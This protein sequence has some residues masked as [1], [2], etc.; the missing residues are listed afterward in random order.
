MKKSKKILIAILIIIALIGIVFLTY[1]VLDEKQQA[2][3]NEEYKLNGYIIK[4][5]ETEEE[6]F[7]EDVLNENEI[8]EEEKIE[9]NEAIESIEQTEQTEQKESEMNIKTENNKQQTSNNGILPESQE[10]KLEYDN[11]STGTIE[12]PKIGLVAPIKEGTDLET[13]AQYVGHFSNSSVW[14]GNVALAAHNRGTSVKHYFDRINELVNGDTIIYKTK[15]GERSYKVISSKEIENTDWSVTESNA[16]ENN[17]I[18]LITC[19]RN[20]PE[21]RLCVIAEEKN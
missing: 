20:Q 6:S 10:I 5:I 8:I 14:D 13:L 21:K 16:N 9:T 4:P 19:I 17:T 2:S 12:I 7:S 1:K 3:K 15:L 18:T 11:N